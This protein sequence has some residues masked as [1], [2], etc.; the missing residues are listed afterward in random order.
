M[1]SSLTPVQTLDSRV[2]TLELTS[3][4][5]LLL[6]QTCIPKE[7]RYIPIHT[8]ETMAEAI[9]TMIVRGAPAIGIAGAFGLVLAA[10]I[11]AQGH[12]SVESFESG[13][14]R[15]AELLRNARPTAVNL[16]WAMDRMLEALERELQQGAEVS[17]V[18]E[19]LSEKAQC[20]LDE[21]ID[22][23]KTMGRLGA[24]L[25]PKGARILTHCNAGALAT[26]GYGTALGVVRAAFAQDPTV[27]VYADE[28]RPRLQGARL[29]TWELI[30]D[31]IPVTLV[32]DGM[33]GS[34][35]QAGRVDLVIVGADRIT[36][37]GDTANKIGTYNLALV[38]H[39]H[40]VPFYVAA[41]TSTIDLALPTGSEIPIEERDPEEIYRIHDEDI[42]PPEARF[43]N[44]AFDVTPARYVTAIITEKGIAR[45]DYKESLAALF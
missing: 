17:Q 1:D 37:N 29:T 24:S 43:Y 31:G 40:G 5:V 10:R 15:D 45:P 35:M 34:L 18:V 33:S 13:L 14:R 12:S 16:G 23:N 22:A 27:E 8:P 30:Q 25:V 11:H 38:A 20:I 44:P 41:P 39:A 9:R 7:I 2:K 21:D 19:R 32:T 42:C 28:T 36:A 26:G 4:G 6:D 3:E